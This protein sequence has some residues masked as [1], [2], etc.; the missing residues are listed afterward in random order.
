MPDI[1]RCPRCRTL[2]YDTASR[3]HG[4][5][6]KLRGGKL[7][8]KGSWAFIF[9]STAVFGVICGTEILNDKQREEARIARARAQDRAVR[10]SVEAWMRE[11]DAT[12]RDGLE[13]GDGELMKRLRGIR[14]N[15]SLVFPVDGVD[16]WRRTNPR[17]VHMEQAEGRMPFARESV[18]NL[19]PART[20]LLT[21]KNDRRGY[22]YELTTSGPEGDCEKLLGEAHGDRK[23]SWCSVYGSKGNRLWCWT[24]EAIE[25]EVAVRRDDRRYRVLLA[26]H[27]DD[28][29][30]R[31]LRIGRIED[32]ASGEVIR[33][34]NP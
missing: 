29:R 25:Y 1:I 18:F 31:G 2:V 8:T 21:F 32:Y 4:C 20:S 28:G 9:L 16:E 33:P 19:A 11:D 15:Y 13:V 26:A 3:C 5:D 6:C 12:V 17:Q 30:L 34:E 27:V 14:E 22:R 23:S 24:E 7:L 10:H